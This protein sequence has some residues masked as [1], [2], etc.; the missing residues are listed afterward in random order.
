MP[1][2]KSL[3]CLKFVRATIVSYVLWHLQL[4]DITDAKGLFK[5]KKRKYLFKRI[6]LPTCNLLCVGCGH[7]FNEVWSEPG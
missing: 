6:A 4:K 2:T 7:V 1:N 5:I 3:L